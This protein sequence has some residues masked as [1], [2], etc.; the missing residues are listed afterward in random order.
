PGVDA[1]DRLVRRNV[2][3]GCCCTFSALCMFLSRPLR[4]DVRLAAGM[5]TSNAWSA[6]GLTMASQNEAPRTSG[7]TCARVTRTFDV[8]AVQSCT[9]DVPS[10]VTV[11][12]ETVSGA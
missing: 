4:G 12:F 6:P 8:E 10:M 5:V 2:M 11:A 1:A 3:S 9:F 7:A